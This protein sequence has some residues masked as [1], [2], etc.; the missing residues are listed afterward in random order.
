MQATDSGWLSRLEGAGGASL[1]SFSGL[2]V[3]EVEVG[4]VLVEF[5]R[6]HVAEKNAGLL[7]KGV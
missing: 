4:V 1:A 3:E 6:M 5:I 7:G 2:D